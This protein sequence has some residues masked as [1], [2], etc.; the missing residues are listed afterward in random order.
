MPKPLLVYLIYRFPYPA[1]DGYKKRCLSFLNFFREFFRIEV[2]VISE[3]RPTKES[4]VFFKELGI[5]WHYFHFDHYFASLGGLVQ[6]FLNHKPLRVN[7]CFSPMIA[8][9]I[10]PLLKQADVVLTAGPFLAEYLVGL[11]GKVKILDLFDDYAQKYERMSKAVTFWMKPLVGREARL[12]ASYQK[13]I[14]SRFDQVWLVSPLEA[15]QWQ[16]MVGKKVK[17]IPLVTEQRLFESPSDTRRSFLSRKV[18]FLGKLSYLPNT[19]AIIHFL[20]EGWPSLEDD[21]EFLIIGSGRSKAV[22]QAAQRRKNVKVL[23]YVRDLTSVLEDV[24]AFLVPVRIQGGIQTKVIDGMA[25][26]KPVFLYRQIASSF[27]GAR[28]RKEFFVC[29][30]A[31]DMARQVLKLKDSPSL[32]RQVAQQGNA[33]AYRLF[34]PEA[35]RQ[36]LLSALGELGFD[37][38]K[39]H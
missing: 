1:L 32:Y 12:L 37:P 4:A 24:F 38:R 7:A 17:H 36:S 23:G 14:V 30:N 34:S 20:Q 8:E 5:K 18:V 31:K 11:S 27:L 2:V 28:H 10:A 15:H 29:N 39:G 3:E 26:K 9:R 13:K 25:L 16:E 6:G 21:F 35:L 22:E 33:Y 19:D